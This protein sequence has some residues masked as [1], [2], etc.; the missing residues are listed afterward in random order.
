MSR[1]KRRESKALSWPIPQRQK[2]ILVAFFLSWIG[3]II[4]L[5]EALAGLVLLNFII[6]FLVLGLQFYAA[7][8][9]EVPP[10]AG[11]VPEKPF[12]SIHIPTYNEPPELVIQSLE[13]LA[14]LNYPAFEVIVLDNNTSDPA[15]WKPVEAACERLG[16]QFRF[17]HYD[18]VTGYKAG[19][20][21][22]CN[23]LTDKRAEFILVIDADYQVAPNLLQKA[24]AYFSEEEI[25]L[26]QFPQA[27]RNA[28]WENCGLSGEYDHFF[29]VYM[30][31]AN[32]LNCVLSTGTVSVIRRSALAAVGGWSGNTI[33]E[34]CELGLRLHQGGFRGVYV[35]EPLGMGLMPTDLK[36]LRVQRERWVF[37]NMQTLA[38]FLGQ[39][40]RQL[41]LKQNLG[42]FIQLTA[43]FNFL[44]IPILAAFSGALGFFLGDN[45]S[46][47]LLL[48]E[49]AVAG[50]GLYLFAKWL[51]FQLAFIR[52]QKGWQRANRAFLAHLGLAWEGAISWLRF[53]TGENIRFKRTNKFLEIGKSFPEIP[54]LLPGLMLLI[55]ALAFWL[56]GMPGFAV[57]A[58]CCAPLF[59][60]VYFLRKQLF[61]THRL[62]QQ[63][64]K[65]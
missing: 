35:N 41:S 26:V 42:I 5:P 60:A 11:S 62:T 37:G 30:N 57:L 53:F 15:L 10:K 21:N 47:Y 28:G 46:T 54:N 45:G 23:T 50:T 4:F 20:L 38:R 17:Y 6:G 43:W 65:A 33:T 49:G 13:A 27:Y 9:K 12:V 52:Q 7:G 48:M 61:E 34:D 14:S 55:T 36:A 64:V 31:M 32:K 59:A 56:G 39:S 8:M 22:I 16:S 63:A 51:F 44:L 25:A 3:A 19:A 1:K 18:N 24:I 58:F 40:K 2:L 29:A